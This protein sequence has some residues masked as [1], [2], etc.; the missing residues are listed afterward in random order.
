MPHNPNL[1]VNQSIQQQ[2]QKHHNTQQKTTL[3]SIKNKNINK[4][5][6]SANNHNTT[7]P[8]RL[9]SKHLR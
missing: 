2:K 8:T 6:R 5:N 3:N 7:K 1:N 9:A 4:V